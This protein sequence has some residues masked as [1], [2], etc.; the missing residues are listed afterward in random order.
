MASGLGDTKQAARANGA[1]LLLEGAGN[2]DVNGFYKQHDLA[3]N[4]KAAYQK[5]FYQYG[6]W[7]TGVSGV[8]NAY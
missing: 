3:V 7:S 8:L 6:S 2:S 4:G 5:I 1:V